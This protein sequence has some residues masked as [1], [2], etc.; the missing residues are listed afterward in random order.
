MCATVTYV[1]DFSFLGRS[2]A[3]V[4]KQTENYI[5]PL[6][7]RIRKNLCPDDIMKHLSMIVNL[8]IKG[9]YIKVNFFYSLISIMGGTTTTA[10]SFE[11][12]S[13]PRPANAKL[14]RSKWATI[15][16]PKGDARL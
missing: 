16:L 13:L 7:E 6:Y 2:D 12:F 5:K 1:T 15:R 14:V 11:T 10:K 9:N 3:A 4:W 8:C